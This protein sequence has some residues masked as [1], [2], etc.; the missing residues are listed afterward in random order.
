MRDDELWTSWKCL[1]NS[2][3]TCGLIVCISIK[4]VCIFSI[5][6]IF[7]IYFNLC[8]PEFSY[9]CCDNR[10]D[11]CYGRSKRSSWHHDACQDD[12][13][14]NNNDDD[15]CGP[16]GPRWQL[17][18]L[19]LSNLPTYL[20]T[21]LFA[22]VTGVMCLKSSSLNKWYDKLHDE[23]WCFYIH[24]LFRS[25]LMVLRTWTIVHAR[26]RGHSPRV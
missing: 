20:H 22:W 26:G 7:L 23:K 6:F 5:F 10:H 18:F 14:D 9:K 25:S 2:F 11:R 3:D 15:K 13:D 16:R 24:I 1:W 17:L 12:D 19:L 4:Q 21:V 8:H